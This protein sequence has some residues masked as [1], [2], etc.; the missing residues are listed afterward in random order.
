[1][2]PESALFA[3]AQA[4][5]DLADYVIFGVPFDRTTSFRPGARLAPRA[6]R[7]ASHNFETFLFE[8]AVDLEDLAICDL[9]DTEE[10]GNADSMVA[11]VSEWAD[12]IHSADRFPIALGGEHSIAPPIVGA[13]GEVDAVSVDAHLDFRES[14]LG[15]V[16]SHACSTR[17]IAD[18]VGMEHVL[19]VGVRSMSAAE[20]EA[21]QDHGLSFVT[22][23]EIEKGGIKVVSDAL[24]GLQRERLYLTIDMD[25]IDP[26]FAPGVGTPE[27]FGL[28]PGLVKDLMG[29]L[30]DR[31]V[32]F[33]VNEVCPP[34]DNGNTAVLAARLVREGIAVTSL[35]KGP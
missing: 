3:D 31:L 9:G 13:L 33:D 27:P 7:E 23:R 26:A 20:A 24:E 15:E 12:R 25:G 35:A 14:Y 17:R 11:G 2:M 4:A 28:S 18:A 6:I 10:Y 19:L 29:L 16:N 32:G 8:H 1:M 21:A 30:G 34:Y 22:A 5:F